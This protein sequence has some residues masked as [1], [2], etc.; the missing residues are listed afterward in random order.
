M[1]IDI[2]ITVAGLVC[3]VGLLLYILSDKPKPAEVGRIMFAFGLLVLL[4]VMGPFVRLR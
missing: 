4:L 2:E 1:T 3:L